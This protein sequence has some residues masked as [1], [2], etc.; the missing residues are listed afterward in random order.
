MV[1]Y[2][3]GFGLCTLNW[4]IFMLLGD[5]LQ[6]HKCKCCVTRFFWSSRTRIP[7]VDKTRCR[8]TAKQ[9]KKIAVTSNIDFSNHYIG[10]MLW[11]KKKVNFSITFQENSILLKSYFLQKVGVVPPWKC[12]ALVLLAQKSWVF[13]LSY[14][15]LFVSVSLMVLDLS[16]KR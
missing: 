9:I 13:R 10:V 5:I 16:N 6:S 14:E 12:H 15:V 3:R 11:K 8:K 2:F 7:F 1:P 4:R